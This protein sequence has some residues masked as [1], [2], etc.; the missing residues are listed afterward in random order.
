MY[1]CPLYFEERTT[2]GDEY[3]S[4]PANTPWNMKVLMKQ[5]ITAIIPILTYNDN[6][7]LFFL[8]F[9]SFPSLGSFLS[10][11]LNAFL[12]E[13]I[14]FYKSQLIPIDAEIQAAGAKTNNK[15]IMTEAK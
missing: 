2:D 12:I 14:E 8:I 4:A 9:P 3:A 7:F 11:P 10:S 15:R 5:H 1:L 6:P 13:S